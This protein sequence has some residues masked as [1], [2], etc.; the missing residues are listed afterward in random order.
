[1]PT[2]CFR[3]GLPTD[4]PTLR[5]KVTIGHPLEVLGRFML[6]HLNF[7]GM[8]RLTDLVKGSKTT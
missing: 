5:K 1:M 6:I 7:N 2:S 3:S 8:T 4:H